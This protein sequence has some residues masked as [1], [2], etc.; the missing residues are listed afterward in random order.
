MIK[1]GAFWKKKNL[2]NSNTPNFAK[3]VLSSNEYVSINKQYIYIF[4]WRPILPLKVA[5]FVC[6]SVFQKGMGDAEYIAAFQQIVMPIAYK[7]NPDLVLV[8]A[9]FDACVG[10]PLGGKIIK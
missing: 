5:L 2:K 4:H 8:S 7:F 9:G 6:L 1:E 10:D 3:N